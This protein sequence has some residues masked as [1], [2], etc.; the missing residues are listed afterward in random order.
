MGGNPMKRTSTAT[1]PRRP[2]QPRA[3]KTDAPPQRVPYAGRGE[4]VE[5]RIEGEAELILELTDEEGELAPWFDDF[6][7]VDVLTR[8]KNRAVTFHISPTPAALLHPVVLHQLEMICRL[9]PTWRI[10]GYAYRKE[11]EQCEADAV[12]RSPYH[13]LWVVE[14]ARRGK[15]QS[16]APSALE[17]K[18][19]PPFVER[20][21]AATGLGDRKPM[22]AP[23]SSQ[24]KKARTVLG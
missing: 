9:E 10:V 5:P 17:G 7:W 14:G 4:F 21:A 19:R 13:Q 8:F 22:L 1:L 20:Y 23:L 15:P 3:A 16:T 2:A 18:P 12:A 11:L 6:W 24:S